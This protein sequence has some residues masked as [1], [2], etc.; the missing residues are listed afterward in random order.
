M[1]LYG[2]FIRSRRQLTAHEILDCLESIDVEDVQGLDVYIDPPCSGILSDGDSDEEDG[3]DVDRMNRHQLLAPA[4]LVVHRYQD[5]ED[6][7]DD[8]PTPSSSVADDERARPSTFAPKRLRRARNEG[9]T[10]GVEDS[11]LQDAGP[12]DVGTQEPRPQGDRSLGRGSSRRPNVEANELR[13]RHWVKRDLRPQQ[14]QWVQPA[15]RAV[16]T[17]SKDSEPIEFFEL[18]FSEEVIRHMVRHSVMYAVGE[19]HNTNFTLSGDKIYCFIG[20]LILTG[21]AP[22][23]RRRMY[24]EFNEDTRNVLVVKSMRRNRFEEIFRYLHVADNQNLRPNDKMAKVR[25]LF[26]LLN[27]KFLTYA[28][29]EKDI[30]IDESMIPYYGRHGCK[31]HIHGK[32]I[33]FGFKAWV[34]ATR[35]GYCLQAE[36]YE[37]RS[38]ARSTGLGE[39]VV[40]KLMNTLQKTYPNTEFSVYCD[41]FFTSPSLLSA[42]Q[43]N[44]VK[45]TGTVRQNRVDHCPLKDV[46]ACK[47]EQRGYYDYKLDKR[48]NILAVRWH[49]NSVVT[50][51]SNEYGVNPIQK[52]KRYST[53]TKNKI[54]IDQP[55]LIS[56]YN[57]YM[58][59]VDRL[60]ANVGVYRIAIRGKKWYSSIL[61]WLIDVAVN[62]CFLLAR[63]LGSTTDTLEHRRA[64]ARS[65]LQKYGDIKSQPGP[66]PAR[67]FS[68]SVPQSVRKHNADHMI[69]TGQERKRCAVCKNKTN[70]MCRKCNVNLHDKCFSM[71]HDSN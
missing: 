65:L 17:L 29:I 35:L 20:I 57:K 24:W 38:E 71:Y 45:I 34:A 53:A 50:L 25:P 3:N 52:A 58:G 36:L 27:E 63:S 1:F 62:N 70:K 26:D 42:L 56:Q 69:L 64:L 60:D 33:R 5:D 39:H 23:P 49:D 16:L 46:K 6:V 47:K 19:H 7:A 21:Y 44:R 66:S 59:G 32:P 12:Q 40:T 67:R 55:N 2:F 14:E 18:F 31:Q 13:P 28:P 9:E 15:P 43:A 22:L 41:N 4:E 10:T 30:S 37:G 8:N 51:L 61:M 48:D 11:G 68:I 54:E